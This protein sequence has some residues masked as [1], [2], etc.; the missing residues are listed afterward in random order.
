MTR[1]F[2]YFAGLVWIVPTVWLLSLFLSLDLAGWDDSIG[3]SPVPLWLRIADS[4]V[5]PMKCLVPDNPYFPK[6]DHI[7]G[8]ICMLVMFINSVLW[9]FVLVYLFR[10]GAD[11]AKPKK[12]DL[13]NAA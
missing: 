9:S 12:R 6:Y 2:Q 13:T 8:M 1:R 7:Y 4:V 5:F 3:L 10:F 11:L